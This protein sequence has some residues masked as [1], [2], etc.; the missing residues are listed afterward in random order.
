MPSLRAEHENA[1][2]TKSIRVFVIPIRCIKSIKIPAHIS[3]DSAFPAPT[4]RR[5]VRAVAPCGSS[6][7][8]H[9]A[10]VSYRSL[11]AVQTLQIRN[12][13]Y[14]GPNNSPPIVP[15]TTKERIIPLRLRFRLSPL[16][17]DLMWL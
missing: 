2:H 3:F 6:K 4:L 16:Y 11:K 14:A 12:A 5:R 9:R 13:F 15:E 17:L 10:L 1:Y 7:V 8:L